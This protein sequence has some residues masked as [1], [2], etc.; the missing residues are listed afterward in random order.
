METARNRRQDRADSAFPQQM[1]IDVSGELVSQFFPIGQRHQLVHDF[2]QPLKAPFVIACRAGKLFVAMH[3]HAV[4][5]TN[6]R[7]FF[8]QLCDTVLDG[9]LHNH[10]LAKR[11]SLWEFGG[12]GV[13][14]GGRK[15]HEVVRTDEP[16]YDPH[17]NRKSS[18]RGVVPDGGCRNLIL[19]AASFKL[20]CPSGYYVP[21]P[22][23]FSSV[24]ERNQESLRCPKNVHWRPIDLA[25]LPTHMRENAE[26]GQSGRKSAGDTVRNR[27]VEGCHPP[28]AESDQQDGSG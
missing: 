10:S 20:A 23:T 16:E 2:L 7:Y 13:C 17:E 14:A 8:S 12:D 15:L 24:G 26:A 9:L 4:C 1:R 25:G 6:L 18:P 19:H 3:V 27:P 22:F 11:T 21:D 5:F 28:R